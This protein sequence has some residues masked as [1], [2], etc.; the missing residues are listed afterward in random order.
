MR[1]KVELDFNEEGVQINVDWGMEQIIMALAKETDKKEIKF[2]VEEY[3]KLWVHNQAGIK[4]A[5]IK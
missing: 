3:A 5:G 2:L 4:N 1:K